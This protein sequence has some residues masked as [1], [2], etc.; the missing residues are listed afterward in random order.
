MNSRFIW[1]LATALALLGGSAVAQDVP[2][3]PAPP[4]RNGNVFDSTAHEPNA[5][6][7]TAQERASGVAPTQQ[8][9]QSE[10]NQVEQLDRQIEQRAQQP[11]G[12]AAGCSSDGK[13]CPPR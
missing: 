5:G 11:T 2:P 4:A 6:A 12:A 1:P 7:T 8:Q 13:D 9:Q 3:P 10:S